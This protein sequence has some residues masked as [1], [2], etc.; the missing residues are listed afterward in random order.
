MKKRVFAL[1][2]IIVTLL[3]LLCSV[4]FAHSG[5]TDANGGHYDHS[6][7]EYHY[8]HGHP[9]HQHPNGI[10][11][12]DE[13]P[14]ETTRAVPKSTVKK[15]SGSKHSGYYGGSGYSTHNSQSSSSSSHEDFESLIQKI[16]EHKFTWT[17]LTYIIYFP[18]I[19]IYA[20][21]VMFVLSVICTVFSFIKDCVLFV[22]RYFR[23]MVRKF[24]DFWNRY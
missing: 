21:P 9:A 7:G 22:I 24:W 17:D 4:S 23:N 14:Q 18:L 16:K 15:S 8:H 6:T 19:F 12:Y 11:P 13:S 5:R 1:W 3:I 2:I 10:C 20:I